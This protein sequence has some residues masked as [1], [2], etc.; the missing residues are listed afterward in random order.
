M[1]G[2]GEFYVL[3]GHSISLVCGYN[4]QSN[5]PA[6]ITWIDPSGNTI[7]SKHLKSDRLDLVKLHIEK[8]QEKDSGIW[9]CILQ[10]ELRN[11][12]FL[13]ALTVVGK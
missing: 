12:T 13:L 3:L 5:P 7:D 8:A 2:P 1:P 4:L 9:K 10:H 11:K 6:K